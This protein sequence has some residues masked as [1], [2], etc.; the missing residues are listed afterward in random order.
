MTFTNDS[1][2]IRQIDFSHDGQFVAATIDRYVNV[3]SLASGQLVW[4]GL[5]V[6]GNDTTK[7]TTVVRFSP[8]GNFLVVGL[9]KTRNLYV[10]RLPTFTQ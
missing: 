8:R 1:A 9:V 4:V 10:Y 5:P 6:P 7:K 2:S 3:Y